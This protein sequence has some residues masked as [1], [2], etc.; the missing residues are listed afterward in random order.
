MQTDRPRHVRTTVLAWTAA[1]ALAAAVP[2]PAWHGVEESPR[3]LPAGNAS[4]G[5]GGGGSAGFSQDEGGFVITSSD[6][7]N[8][9]LIGGR[10]QARFDYI[11]WD[12]DFERDDTVTFDLIRARLFFLGHLM[13]EDNRYFIQLAADSPNPLFSDDTGVGD[14][15]VLD[16]W[17]KHERA[18][19]FALK[20]GQFKLPF[21]R[22]SL[23]SSGK[24]QFPDRSLA[25]EATAVPRRD[26]GVEL[27]GGF[28]AGL[29]QYQFAV[30]NGDGPNSLNRDD[31]LAVTGRVSF[32]PT[33]DYGY[34][35]GDYDDS[36]ELASTFG[37]ALQYLK[38]EDREPSVEWRRYNLD[39]GIKMRRL[40]VQGEYFLTQREPAGGSSSDDHSFYL[41]G[42]YFLE[43]EEVEIAARASALFPDGD[44][45]DS[46][47][48]SVGVNVFQ[49]GHRLKWQAA[50]SFLD[51]GASLESHRFQA[52]GQ[53][54]F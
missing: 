2:A 12:E 3:P 35:E 28:E 42:G 41:Q 46:W 6:G 37:V 7:E 17:F 36:E 22:Q 54:W 48:Y 50:Y 11:G 51:A 32:N 53:I 13:G 47:E 27:S 8:K 31:L 4:G 18:E 39:G 38:N 9:L 52:Q 23:T 44:A 20:L 33:G 40:S 25:V 30:S 1:I 16:A 45:D 26:V 24:L 15:E 14:L 19:E 34:A 29:V 49:W 10:L 5:A 21:G 43:P